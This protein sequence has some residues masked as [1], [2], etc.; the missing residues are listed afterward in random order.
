MKNVT[1][2]GV[3]ALGSHTAQFLRNEA[4]LKV[5]DFDRVESKNIL[6]QFHTK[7]SVGKNKATSIKDV[8]NFL[9]GVKI[10]AIPY[11][12]RGDNVITLLKGADLLLDCLD[13]AESRRLVQSYATTLQ[14]P[15]LHGALAADG[16]FGRIV[17]TE[18]FIIDGESATG[19]AT[20][21]A[22]EHL[23]FIAVVAAHMARA[24]QEYLRNGQKMGFSINPSGH[25]IRTT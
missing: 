6:S 11:E 13:N 15:C 9:Y 20:C 18:R 12:L 22:G 1:I 17:W 24:A 25:A 2:V 21:E 3:G 4:D 23:P 10:E 16:Q 19:A 14:V 8:F 5:I 7:P